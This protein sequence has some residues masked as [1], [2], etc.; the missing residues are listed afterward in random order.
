MGELLR[1]YLGS[2]RKSSHAF[3]VG[4]SRVIDPQVADADLVAKVLESFGSEPEDDWGTVGDEL[5]EAI[6][7]SE[8]R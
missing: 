3:W 4:A 8:A 7:G 6:S 2:S 5:R 1:A